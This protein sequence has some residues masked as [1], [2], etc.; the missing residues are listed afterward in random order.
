MFLVFSLQVGFD[1]QKVVLLCFREGHGALR[2]LLQFLLRLHKVSLELVQ[3]L[4]VHVA[5]FHFGER[6]Q[7][8]S[9]ADVASLGIL[10][11]HWKVHLVDAQGAVLC[12]R[13]FD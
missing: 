6:G 9:I 7:F 3:T 4:V 5:H 1:V 10:L 12:L 11:E 13:G 8:T 2:L